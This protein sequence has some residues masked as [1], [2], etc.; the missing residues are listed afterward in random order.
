MTKKPPARF[1]DTKLISSVVS[2]S[3]NSEF[4]FTKIYVLRVLK[5]RE[6]IRPSYQE[7]GSVWGIRNYISPPYLPDI[8]IGKDAYLAPFAR[9]GEGADEILLVGVEMGAIFWFNRSMLV[10]GVGERILLF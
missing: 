8:Q 6:L 2:C 7:R 3:E 5:Q 4:A 1:S 10:G 9:L